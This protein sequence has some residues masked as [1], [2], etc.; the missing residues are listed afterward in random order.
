MDLDLDYYFPFSDVSKTLQRINMYPF[1]DIS[2]YILMCLLVK[3]DTPQLGTPTF[4]RHHSFASWLASML[5]CFAGTIIGN[6]LTGEP[7]I[8][9]FQNH[10]DI[11]V[12]T[13]VWYVLNYAPFDLV[14][15]LAK[16]A[17]VH[18]AVCLLKEIQRTQK[19]FD[20]VAAGVRLYPQAYLLNVLIGLVKAN[21]SPVMLLF[22][23]LVTGQ[24]RPPIVGAFSV[25]TK[26]CLVVAIVFLME[27]TGHLPAQYHNHVYLGAAAFFVLLR[28]AVKLLGPM[29]PFYPFEWLAGALL[30]GGL[31]DAISG[32]F[33]QGGAASRPPSAAPVVA[34]D[35]SA[36]AAANGAPK[37]AATDKKRE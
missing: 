16:F 23:R 29:D 30:F 20:G 18:L 31:A 33:R 36:G 37:K 34:T 13:I 9:P 32:L 25:T 6:G 5:M 27:H 7:L 17:P 28:L 8:V 19:V 10:R 35:G 2:H 26:A 3:E 12:A 15:K 11:L 24:F 21:G 22:A 1:F 14:Y 4:S